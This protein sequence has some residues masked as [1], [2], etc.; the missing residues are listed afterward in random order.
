VPAAIDE[1]VPSLAV[2]GRDLSEY[3]AIIA[4]GGQ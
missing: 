4:G 1:A 2:L 3:A